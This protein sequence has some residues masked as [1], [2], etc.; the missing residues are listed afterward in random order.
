MILLVFFGF[1]KFPF[2]TLRITSWVLCC[3][4][5]SEVAL[6]GWCVVV[7]NEMTGRVFMPGLGRFPLDDFETCWVHFVAAAEGFLL[8]CCFVA[9]LY[10]AVGRHCFV[11]VASVV[12]GFVCFEVCFPLVF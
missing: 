6:D 8:D 4:G 10:S 5:P 9:C 3:V 7:W 1:L 11:Q 12:V 2:K